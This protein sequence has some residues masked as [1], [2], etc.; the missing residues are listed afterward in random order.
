[1]FKIN[2]IAKQESNS[3][4]KKTVNRRKGNEIKELGIVVDISSWYWKCSSHL[5]AGQSL[6]PTILVLADSEIRNTDK[7]NL[8]LN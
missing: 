7:W 2:Q 5:S 6:L 1:M 8:V 3:S 4:I